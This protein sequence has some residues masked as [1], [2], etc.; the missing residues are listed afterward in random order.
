MILCKLFFLI[1]FFIINNILFCFRLLGITPTT[2][3]IDGLTCQSYRPF[4]GENTDYL[5]KKIPH[6]HKI[7]SESN[8]QTREQCQYHFR[9]YPWGC[10]LTSKIPPL[11][12]FLR[13]GLISFFIKSIIYNLFF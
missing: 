6:L 12:R 2:Q 1:N 5:C 3:L 7:L 10:Q 13:Q 11:R 9:D 8:I 4:L